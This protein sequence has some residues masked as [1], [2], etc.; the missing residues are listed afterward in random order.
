M[1]SLS[2][3]STEEITDFRKFTKWRVIQLWD[4]DGKACNNI[5][6]IKL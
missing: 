4:I 3:T 2:H 1:I 6:V 5:P